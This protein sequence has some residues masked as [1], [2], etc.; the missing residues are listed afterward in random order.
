[1][2]VLLLDTIGMLT[3]SALDAMGRNEHWTSETSNQIFQVTHRNVSISHSRAHAYKWR[4]QCR[5]LEPVKCKRL[6]YAGK[7]VYKIWGVIIF[8]LKFQIKIV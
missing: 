6:Y 2:D 3:Q 8:Q 7:L 1:M 5:H 4:P